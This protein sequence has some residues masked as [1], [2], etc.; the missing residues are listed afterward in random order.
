MQL[1]AT[2]TKVQLLRQIIQLMRPKR[3]SILGEAVLTHTLDKLV[4]SLV[5]CHVPAAI[6]A[7]LQS[8]V[9]VLHESFHLSTRESIQIGLHRIA[10]TRGAFQKVHA[11][12]GDYDLHISQS[13]LGDL[14]LF[15]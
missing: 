2:Q 1:V 5:H 10:S 15:V 6:L 14:N 4:T 7:L 8:A 3:P 13:L 12:G 9:N 11:S